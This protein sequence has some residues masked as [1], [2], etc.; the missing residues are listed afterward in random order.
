MR[1]S[2]RGDPYWLTARF[3]STCRQCGRPIHKGD[4]LFYF[5]RTKTPYCSKCGE[6]HS[7][8]FQAEAADEYAY[9]NS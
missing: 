7:R 3:D 6:N 2:Y 1:S 9:N 5:P 4:E 8:R